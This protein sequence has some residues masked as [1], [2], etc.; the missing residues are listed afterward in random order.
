M[1]E[2]FMPSEVKHPSAMWSTSLDAPGVTNFNM[3]CFP[4]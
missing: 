4:Q 1:V 2:P 3:L